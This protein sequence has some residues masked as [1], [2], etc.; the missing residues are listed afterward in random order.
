MSDLNINDYGN[1]IAKSA[2]KYLKKSQDAITELI[3]QAYYQG[4]DDKSAK[5]FSNWVL[6]NR[7]I[8]MVL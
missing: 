1:D 8:P 4:S 6:G 2:K 7:D 5:T 3:D